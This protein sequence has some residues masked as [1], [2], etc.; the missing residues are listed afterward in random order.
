MKARTL[1]YFIIEAATSL[2][3]NSLMSLAS[4]VTVALSILILGIFLVMV[5]NLNHIASVLESQVQVSVYLK[6]GLT[7]SEMRDIGERIAKVP[8]VVKVTF[9]S[10]EEA[11]QRFRSR[12]GD[13]QGLLNALGEN[14]LP[15]G[16]EVK[17]D[18]PERV[19]AAAQAIAGFKGVEAAKFGQDV[20]EHLFSLTRLARI[21]GFALILFLA[22]AALFIIANTIRI[23]VF[24]RRREI[25]IMKYVGATDWFIRWP[26]LI[27]GIILGASGSLIAVLL[28]TKL[29]G[30]FTEQVYDALAFLPIIPKYPFLNN[31]SIVLFVVGSCIGA[32]GSTISLKKFMNV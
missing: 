32:V 17:V 29:Y 4:V 24:A 9:V 5:L 13:Q 11:L 31:I 30:M 16:Y 22:L 15:N 23:T 20:I 21:V 25:G 14:P 28:L 12:L 10:K 6:D 26:F 1:E 27:E 3:Q 7:E 2:K 8:G 19:R 18:R